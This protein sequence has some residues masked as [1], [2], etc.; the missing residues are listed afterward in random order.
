[1]EISVIEYFLLGFYSSLLIRSLA[2]PRG[3]PCS[4]SEKV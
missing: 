2:N 3:A 1:M 4:G